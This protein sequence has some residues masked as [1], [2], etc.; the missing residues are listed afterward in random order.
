MPALISAKNLLLKYDIS[1]PTDEKGEKYRGTAHEFQDYAYKLASDLNDM[2]NLKIYMR[3]TKL[4]PR[5]LMEEAYQFVA[6]VQEE[7][8]GR[9]YMWKFKQV[10]DKYKLKKELKNYD[11][12]F[13]VKKMRQ[14]RDILSDKIVKKNN[15]YSDNE[16][17]KYIETIF[18]SLFNSD[19]KARI[20]IV[21]N[22]CPI[23]PSIFAKFTSQV[24][25]I[26]LSSKVSKNLKEIYGNP[27]ARKFITK[28]F[29][30]HN[31]N[32]D[33]FD[34]IIVNKFWNYLPIEK[35]HEFV[36]EMNKLLKIG[37]KLIV[38]N[39]SSNKSEQKWRKFMLGNE[40]KY[41]FEKTSNNEESQKLFMNY[42]FQ[43][44]NSYSKPSSCLSYYQK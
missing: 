38:S 4:Y 31:Y 42:G 32:P 39:K 22:E 3:L 1:A 35:E 8:K 37:G 14:V 33:F 9:L 10:K 30:S 6:D 21:G 29:F 36:K 12:E 16:I 7:R 34:L 20:L 27:I 26:E 13:V 44:Q 41:F 19:K 2:E 15:N 24:Y 23:L 11:Y 5:F 28:E 25:G 40:E 18:E 43:L 17:V